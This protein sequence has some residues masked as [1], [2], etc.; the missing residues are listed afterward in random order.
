MIQ[1]LIRRLIRPRRAADPAIIPLKKHG[2]APDRINACAL[3]V[4]QT[5]QQAG[6]KAFVVGGAVRDLLMGKEP[7]DYDVATD[8]TP[9][10]VRDLFR[11][12]RI[13]GRRFRIVHVMCGRDTI[14][15]TT[16][17]GPS[18]PPVNGDGEEEEAEDVER[19][20]NERGRLLRDNV[21]GTQ[22]EDAARRDFTVN[23][24][25]YDPSTAEIW[26]SLGGVADLKRG[27][28]RII[29]DPETRYREDPVRM[30]RAVRLAAKLQLKLDPAT[31]KP[32]RGMADRLQEVPKAR[33][34]DE[35]LK[36]FLSGH[37]LESAKHLRQEGLHHGVLPLLDVVLEQPMGERFVTLA[38]QN[39]DER[40]ADDKPVSPAFL[41]ATL[42]WHEVLAR[43]QKCESEDMRPI[44]ALNEAMEDVI[45]QQVENLAIPRRYTAAMREIWSLQPRFL[46]R[47]GQRP[48]RL[49]EHPRFRAAYDFL[50][51]R[52]Q[53]GEVEADVGQ[54]WEQFQH[55][56]SEERTRMLVK[57]EGPAR[58]RRRRRKPGAAATGSAE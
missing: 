1:K 12:S 53:S 44:P 33:M 50:Q 27:V 43:W 36:L 58:P 31:R 57:G 24:L 21:F 6:Y 14:E 51:L 54:W 7:K 5:L 18:A 40:M 11:R 16:F 9:E 37:A 56:N 30:L 48:F 49:L 32:I 23:A 41:F 38:L 47:S 55:A 46:Q 25:Y 10:E 52:C 15:V 4:C 34:F 2:V 28:L 13:I 22:A 39:T 45:Q 35:M 8:A 19:H 26:D 3:S 29:G 42:L 17:R 20:A